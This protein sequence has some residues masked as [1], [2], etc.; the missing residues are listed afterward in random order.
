MLLLLVHPHFPLVVGYLSDPYL[1]YLHQL[2][3]GVPFNHYTVCTIISCF[4]LFL[5]IGVGFISYTLSVHSSLCC[6]C[7][8]RCYNF[9]GHHELMYDMY[10]TIWSGLLALVLFFC[11]ASVVIFWLNFSGFLKSGLEGLIP[12]FMLLFRTALP[13]RCK[14]SWY[15]YGFIRVLLMRS[16]VIRVCACVWIWI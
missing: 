3:Q 5:G 4:L 2:L 12:I 7:C 13:V 8:C 6:L 9:A 11:V 15:C 10:E 16:W 14:H 1:F